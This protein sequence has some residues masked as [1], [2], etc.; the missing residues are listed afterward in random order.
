MSRSANIFQ[1][2]AATFLLCVSLL[3]H[4]AE[5]NPTWLYYGGDRAFNRYAPLSQI[6]ASNVDD[7]EILW[8]RPAV[9]RSITNA[10]PQLRVS[11]NLR[12]TPIVVEGVLYASNGVGLVEAI[13]TLR[14]RYR[15]A[16]RWHVQVESG[17]YQGADLLFTIVR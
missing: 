17:E 6:S 16:E 2:L 9:D 5:S 10:F 1:V 3:G 15:L 4:A 8:R 13:N 7:L 11:G 14:L 12:A